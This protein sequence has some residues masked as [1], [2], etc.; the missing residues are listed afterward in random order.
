[1]PITE[2]VNKAGSYMLVRM[3]PTKSPPKTRSK[4]R[5]PTRQAQEFLNEKNS[6]IKLEL[7][8]N[9][10]FTAKDYALHLT[11][12]DANMPESLEEVERDKRNYIRRLKR[13]YEAAGLEFKWICVIE[14]GNGGRWHLH[15][16][17][18]GGISRDVLENKWGYGYCNADRLQFTERGLKGLQRYIVKER[19]AYK[20]WSASRN[21][22]KPLKPKERGVRRKTFNELWD[23]ADDRKTWEQRYPDYNFV[24]AEPV[25]NPDFGERY[26]TVRMCRKDAPLAFV[27]D[28]FYSGVPLHRRRKRKNE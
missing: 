25:E 11:Y 26:I 10:N 6:E 15:T 3:Y 1:M 22:S 21:L 17:I 18:S 8:I 2:K 23:Y 28:C 13:V 5:T 14:R 4:R 27:E 24:E 19:I 12:S 16:L 7:L 20:R 9:E